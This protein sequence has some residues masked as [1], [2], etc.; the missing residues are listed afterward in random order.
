[1]LAKINVTFSLAI[2]KTV[3]ARIF[4]LMFVV[5]IFL[6]DSAGLVQ[7]TRMYY[8]FALAKG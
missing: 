1:M 8:A 6:L 4:R 2:F 7:K 5:C 3:A